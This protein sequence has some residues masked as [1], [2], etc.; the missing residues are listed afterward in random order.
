M[1][2]PGFWTRF[3]MATLAVWRVTHLFVA[4]D[5]P[6]DVIVRVRAR[7]G[8]GVLGRLLDCFYC[9]SLWVAAPMAFMVCRD[10]LERVVTWVALSGAACLSERLTLRDGTRKV[11]RYELL[12]SEASGDAQRECAAEP[13]GTHHVHAT[14]H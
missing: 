7:L 10:P 12:R 8:D 1:S 13:A 6:A 4:E 14:G 2:D 9:L 11:D 5:G 3:V